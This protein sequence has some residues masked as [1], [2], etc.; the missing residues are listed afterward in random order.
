MMNPACKFYGIGLGVAALEE[1]ISQ[2]VLK[3]AFWGWIV[4]TLI[5]FLPFLFIVRTVGQLLDRRLSP[6][7]AGL[8]YYLLAG[9][10]GLAVEWFLIGLSPWSG[11]GKQP[12]AMLVLQIGMFSFWS[13][14]AFA[15]RMLLDQ[16]AEVSQIRTRFKWF[17]VAGLA[18]IY[19]VSFAAPKKLQ[20][21]SGIG[22]ILL[23]FVGSNFYYFR[24]LRALGA[25]AERFLNLR[26][27]R[28]L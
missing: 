22:S 3:N 24:Y 25:D 5:A 4:P 19:A 26:E 8:I 20:F 23:I 1:F 11:D 21:V 13:A 18:F 2:G 27:P 14:V 17:L 7:K 9:G 16:R 10:V 6:Q 12:L 15:P 28:D